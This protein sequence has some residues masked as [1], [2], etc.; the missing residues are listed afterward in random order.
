LQ[1]H[2]GCSGWSYSAWQ[3]PF[4]PPNI[5]NS[6]WLSYYSS[7]FDFD[8]VEIDSSFYGFL[9]HHDLAV[10]EAGLTFEVYPMPG[11]IMQK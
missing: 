5:E 6:R 8:F 11:S 9:M 4:Y 3:G 7:V 1:Y 2:I 10:K